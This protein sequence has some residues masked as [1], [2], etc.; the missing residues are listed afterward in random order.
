MNR[1]ELLLGAAAAGL[2]AALPA[3]AQ[4]SPLQGQTIK[5]IV[6]FAAGSATDTVARLYAENIARTIGATIVVENRVGANGMIGADA[7]AKAGPDGLTLLVGTN[8][9]NAA[10]PALFNRVPFDHQKDFTP[11]SFLGS[12]PLIVGVPANSPFQT[13]KDL[14]AAAKARPGQLNF[15]SASASQR[16]STEMLASMA[17]IKMNMVPYRA[18]PQAVTD[19]IAARIDLFVADMAVMLPQV[20]ANAIRALA[21]TSAARVSQLPNIA[22]V[23]EAGGLK[24][25]ELIAWFGLFGPAGLPEPMVASLNAAARRAGQ[26]PEVLQRL[27]EGLGMS[28]ATSTPGELAQRVREETVKWQKAV[29]DAGIEKV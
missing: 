20:Q 22:T 8:S 3:L 9:T 18:S 4:T 19:L 11:I 25:Y 5:L 29:D 23:E 28:V 2:V 26:A 27:G 12:V 10:A 24:G 17:G 6:P 16:V 21:V 13:L 15:A 7:V 1:R 14:I